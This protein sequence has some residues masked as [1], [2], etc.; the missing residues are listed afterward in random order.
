M[1]DEKFAFC[2]HNGVKKF[3]RKVIIV[4][5]ELY[6]TDQTMPFGWLHKSRANFASSK[7]VMLNVVW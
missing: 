2:H 7:K 3:K 5:A 4:N 1:K 6:A